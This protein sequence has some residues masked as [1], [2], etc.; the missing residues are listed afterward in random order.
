MAKTK[1]KVYEIEVSK[2]GFT[3]E[4]Y[5]DQIKQF[6]EEHV[7]SSKVSKSG[8]SLNVT[9]PESFSKR[10]LKMRV[11]K[12][13]YSSGLKSD[14]RLISMEKSGKMGYQIMER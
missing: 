1:K 10:M 9:V 3:K 4:K 8:S 12:F 11:N 7:P 13:L 14:F 2:L 5:V 6:I